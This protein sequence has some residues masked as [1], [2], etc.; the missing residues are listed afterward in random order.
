MAKKSEKNKNL[1][2]IK[3]NKFVKNNIGFFIVIFLILLIG[4]FITVTS[5]N[6][7]ENKIY[8]DDVIE[9]HYFFSK[10]CSHC[11]KQRSFNSK[12][13]ELYPNLKI[14]GHDTANPA[15]ALEVYNRF[16]KEFDGL[17]E[18]QFPGTPL[19]IIGDEYNVGYGT[20]ETTGQILVDMIE[21]QQELIDANW[22]S[23]KTKTI[24]LN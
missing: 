3:F 6:N 23:S 24:D 10:T 15:E 22:N 18:N 20:D 17:D 5:K 7:N 2:T 4:A 11:I 19:T 21:K 8:G 9:M 16:A 14:I 1:F 12:L 13:E